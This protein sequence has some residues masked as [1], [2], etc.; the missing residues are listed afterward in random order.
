MACQSRRA[1]EVTFAACCIELFLP[2]AVPLHR[3]LGQLSGAR[4]PPFGGRHQALSAGLW[5]P[6]AFRRAGLRFLRLP[7]PAAGLARSCDGLLE[8]SR[9]QRGCHVPH[10]QDALGELAS[11]RRERGTV[12]ADPLTPA[13]HDSLKDVSTTFV[14]SLR[15]DASI[16]ASR[17]FNSIPAFPSIDFGWGSLLS[18][19]FAFT[20]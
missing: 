9:P 3:P 11:R 16:E 19:L 8:D 14:P 5:I 12:S 1:P 7:V 6:R 10:R 13:D 4:Q 18:F 17:M 2:V 20:A 15:Y